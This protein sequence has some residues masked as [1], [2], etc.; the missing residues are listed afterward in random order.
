MKKSLIS[1]A[2]DVVLPPEPT[3]HDP[4]RAI[5]IALSKLPGADGMMIFRAQAAL[6]GKYAEGFRAG[7]EQGF[8]AGYQGGYLEGLEDG[9]REALDKKAREEAERTTLK[10]Q[11]RAR[12]V[13]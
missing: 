8:S 5:K 7:R 6:E 3:L 9:K 11:A 1:A 4:V 12:R 13:V 10:A 2:A